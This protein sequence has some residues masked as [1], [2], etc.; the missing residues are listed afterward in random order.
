MRA[1]TSDY[2]GPLS[3]LRVVELGSVNGQYCGKLLADMGADVV[4][5]EPPGRGENSRGFGPFVEGES[6]YTMVFNRNKRSLTLD[7]RSNR[8]KEILRDLLRKA[9][10]LVENFVPGTLEKMGFS[11][12]A[13]QDLNARLVV[14]RISGFGQSG[15]LSRK[16]C[17][18]VIAQTM[19]GLMDITGDPGGRPTMSG[20]YVVDYSTGL[21]ATIGTLGALQARE[22]TGKGQ[23]VD[24]N[25]LDSAMS[26]LMTAIPEQKL[27]G[28]TMTRRGNRDRYAAPCNTFPTRDDAWVHLAVAGDLM[29]GGLAKLMG[30]PDIASD[31]RFTSNT[32][33]MENVEALEAL[34]IAWTRTLSAA[35]LLDRLQGAGIPSAK[36]ATVSDLVEHPH[37]A[38]RNQII[39]MPHSKAGAVPMQ[40]FAIGFGDSPM[41]LR[42]PPPML[43]QHTGTVLEEWLSM[44]V[45]E[46]SALRADGT[47]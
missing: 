18:D 46:I 22:R 37:L 9:D 41:Q 17:F 36:V 39:E 47:I 19:S 2:T 42:H 43:G 34:I 30:R 27:L 16:P 6:L 3:G 23:V 10:V 24:V 13:L 33:R 1:P 5:V 40:G 20:T 28:Q 21:Y 44:N 32:A 29:F 8:G 26:M 14:T 45:Q 35:E 7:L 4:K 12:E 11:W 25:L 15:P 38:H 31:T